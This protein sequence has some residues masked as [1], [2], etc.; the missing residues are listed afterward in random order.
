MNKNPPNKVLDT[1]DTTNQFSN[2]KEFEA[3]YLNKMDKKWKLP[4]PTDEELDLIHVMAKKYLKMLM[5]DEKI[6][7]ELNKNKMYQLMFKL[8][9]VTD[10]DEN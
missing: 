9:M 1:F 3:Y 10:Q 4:Q 5:D 2:Y 8:N 6:S 7:N